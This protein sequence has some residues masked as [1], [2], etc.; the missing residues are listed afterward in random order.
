[1]KTN[2]NLFRKISA[3]LAGLTLLGAACTKYESGF[4]SPTMQYSVTTFKI[5]KG[6]LSSSNSLV[7]DGSTIP[8]NVKWTH[9]YDSTGQVVDTLF[10]TLHPVGI[11][12]SA[13]NPATDTTFEKIQAKRSSEDLP[14]ININPKSGVIEANAGTYYLPSGT[15][16]M[17][18]E[19]SNSA[20]TQQLKNAMKLVVT[21]GKALETSPETGA[22]SLSR[23][24]ANTATGASNGVAFNGN[25]NPFVIEK[26]TRVSDTPNVVIVR[27][28]DK[29]GT[30]FNPS[31]GEIAKRPNSG[32]NPTPPFLQNLQ[33][34]APDT[35]KALDTAMYLRF[36]LVPFP[37]ASLGNGFNMYYRIPTKFVHIDSTSTWAAN[38]GGGYYEDKGDSHYLGSFQDD[39]YDFAIRI[40]MRIQ[41]PGSYLIDLKILNV[42]HR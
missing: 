25:N 9:I 6:R 23:L 36:P 22:Y 4:I 2:K 21:D 31:K 33:D 39:L 38:V 34:Y 16:T 13:Y 12:T 27:I 17:D 26:I 40:P 19:V 15:Y 5:I 20:G 37:I 18:L 7:S 10:K 14:P 35:Y 24:I 41:V 42:T 28:T 1:M 30:V 8:L 32:L 11:W 29:H 3:A